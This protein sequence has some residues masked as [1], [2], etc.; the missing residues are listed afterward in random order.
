MRRWFLRLSFK[1]TSFAGWQRQINAES[2]QGAIDQA[3][4]IL[5]KEPVL[6]TGCGRTDTGVHATTFYAHFD[7]TGDQGLGIPEPQ[8]LKSLNAILPDDI[9]IHDVFEVDPSL[10][11]R[12][13]AVSRTYEYRIVSK[14][15]PFLKGLVTV[16]HTRPAEEVLNENCRV[17]VG[18]H[19]F[20]SFSKSHTQT[21]T[22]I[23][24]LTRADWSNRNGLLVF[25]ITADR[26]LRGMVRAIVGTS[27]SGCSPSEMLKTLNDR[28][29]SAA[30]PSAPAEG[31]FLTDVRYPENSI[32]KIR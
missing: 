23:C 6:T 21:K 11:A 3:L 28:N 16:M 1:G 5:L 7:R 8:L 4:S 27:L 19:D 14:R 22:N 10:H 17:L 24:S 29:R 2:V 13:S 12:F 30:G 15:D 25:T 18:Q 9:L 20:T 32:P 26:F 31:L